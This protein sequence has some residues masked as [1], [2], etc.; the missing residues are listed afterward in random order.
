MM[1]RGNNGGVN[2]VRG[3][4]VVVWWKINIDMVQSAD[5]YGLAKDRKAITIA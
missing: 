1:Q 5:K 3:V 2:S 4:Q